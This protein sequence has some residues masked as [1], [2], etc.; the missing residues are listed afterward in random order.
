MWTGAERPVGAV[1][2]TGKVL[3]PLPGTLAPTPT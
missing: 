1:N 2:S 3:A